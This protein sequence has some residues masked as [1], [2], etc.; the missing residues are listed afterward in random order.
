ILPRPVLL[1][2]GAGHIGAALTHYASRIGFEVVVV[3]DRASFA[4]RERLPDAD[5]VIVDSVVEVARR[6]LK[7]PE[8]YVVLVTRGHRNDAVALRE[9]IGSPCA[10]IGMIGS[11]RKVLTIY[12]EFLAEGIATPE[13]LARVHA[14][15]GL[16]IGA[17]TVDEIAVSI[18]A[19]LIA[20]R[21]GGARHADRHCA[22]GGGVPADGDAE[23]ALAVR[24]R[25]RDQSGRPLAASL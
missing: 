25:E 13:Q 23:A 19:E 10:Y 6:W 18:A 2:M 14:P 11:R 17:L 7:T 12:E 9:V 15:I 1:I 22:D 8:T 21:R 20:V 24:Q 16:D 5:Q 3:D 4:N